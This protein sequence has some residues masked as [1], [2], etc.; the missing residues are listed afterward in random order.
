[1]SIVLSIVISN[2]LFAQTSI[3]DIQYTT[4]ADDGTYPSLYNGQEVTT[5][6]IV[7]AI[8]FIGGNYFISS[9]T[10]GAWNGIFIYDFNYSPEI[11]DSIIITGYV[12]EY[13][14]FTELK[15]LSSFE[16]KSTSNPVPETV[17]IST[18]QI[19]DEAYEGVL[20]EVNDCSVSGEF[21]NSGNWKVNDGSGENEI[22]SGI[23]DLQD[24]G[25][26]LVI[27]YPFSGIIGVIGLNYGSMSVQPRFIE[28]IQSDVGDL[29]LATEDKNVIGDFSFD[30]PVRVA[31]LNQSENITSYELNMTY[32]V[33]VFTY[34]GYDKT[35]TLSE[36]GT[37]IDNTT[38]GNIS[39]VF[40]GNITC[41][42]ILT[43]IKLQFT[44]VSEGVGNLQF[45]SPKINGS[46]VTYLSEGTLTSYLTE[47]DKPIGDTVTVVQRPLLNIPSIVIP[48]EI[49]TIECFA[50]ETTT[51]WDAELRFEDIAVSLSISQSDYNSDLQKWTLQATIPEVDSYELYDLRVTASG[52]ILDDVSNSVKIID[53]YKDDYYFVH[54]TDTH[55]PGHSF[56]GDEGY[57]TD[58][59]ELDDLYEVIKDINLI[60]PEFVLLTGD[61]IN[62]GELEDFECLRHHSLTV[63]LLEKFEVPVF[64]VPGN[65]DL[66]GWDATP[67]PQGTARQEWWKFF[68]WRQSVIPP[69]KEE[70][71]VHDYSFDY[72]DVH[73]VGLE[74]YDNYDSYMY[75]VYGR[76]SFIPSQITWLE[77]DLANAGSKTKVLFYHF[78]FKGELDL[79]ALGVDMALWGHA[80]SNDGDINT[81][82]Y[83]LRTDNVCDG[84]KAYRVIRVNGGSLQP[85]NTTYT[86]STG[87]NLDIS[88]SSVNNGSADSLAATISNNH[89]QP[90]SNTLVKFIMPESEY[91]YSVTNGTLEQIINSEG[92][93]ICY[94]NVNLAANSE[95]TV[96]IKKNNSPASVE[97]IFESEKNLKQNYPN[98]FQQNT[99]IDFELENK[100][101][102]KLYVYNSTGQQTKVLVDETKNSGQYSVKWNGTNN[103]GSQVE[104]GVYFYKYVVNGRQIAVRQMIYIK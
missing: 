15:N 12:Y 74:S 33:S 3:Y 28:D 81:H 5:G 40:S 19:T 67:P 45:S 52:G 84:E 60:N 101:D 54:I 49:L 96:S 91:E 88:F 9:S 48:G 20:V 25:F 71:Y 30:M 97:G 14:G 47:C 73:Y 89:N 13:N 23:Y 42:D 103:S 68:G 95:I 82:P 8:D 99:Q 94:V 35:T 100:A 31:I 90:F 18:A 65:H 51:D 83:Y 16:V 64:I 86:Y 53:Q 24:E 44:A 59:S 104:D 1:M 78:D 63:E 56:Y 79:P 62:E 43:L 76:E 29:I 85:E 21:D 50:A 93:S 75:D 37:V 17:K 6:G 36:P 98:P 4:T 66:G 69:V 92:N 55:L 26:P 77:N 46:E 57:E 38:E 22:R 39:L 11:G 72:G 102:V 41:D 27:D 7:T 58:E 34:V 32:N 2:T 61:L 70:F 80:H 10:S 87:E